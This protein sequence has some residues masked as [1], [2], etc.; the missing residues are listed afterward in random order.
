MTDTDPRP[1]EPE[2]LPEEEPMGPDPEP[3]PGD[4]DDET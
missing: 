3:G 2:V 4:E 1:V